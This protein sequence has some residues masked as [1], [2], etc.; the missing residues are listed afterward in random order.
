MYTADGLDTLFDWL[1]RELVKAG[2]LRTGLTFH[3]LRK[4]LGKK[5]ADLGFS[6]NDIAAANCG[7][8]RWARYQAQGNPCMG[9][10]FHIHRRRWRAC[11]VGL[12]IASAWQNRAKM[13]AWKLASTN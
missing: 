8:A 1:K 11:L 2:K 3:G 12:R 9:L 5:A 7:Q 13:Q 4:S 10:A 6:E